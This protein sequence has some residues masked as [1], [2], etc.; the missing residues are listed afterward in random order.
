MVLD[1]SRCHFI[2]NKCKSSSLSFLYQVLQLSS[3]DC[4]ANA[5]NTAKSI[6]AL[7][8]TATLECILAALDTDIAVAMSNTVVLAV[9]LSIP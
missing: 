9:S 1:C 4:K 8:T 6:L 5:E 2:H 3:R 7:A